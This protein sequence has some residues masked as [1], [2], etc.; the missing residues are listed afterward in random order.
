M[1]ELNGIIRLY[2]HMRFAMLISIP[3]ASS[4]IFYVVTEI[5]VISIFAFVTAFFSVL[6]FTP[7]PKEIRRTLKQKDFRDDRI[8]WYMIEDRATGDTRIM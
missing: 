4:L 6:E 8:V 7:E 2:R 3:M 1:G 5:P